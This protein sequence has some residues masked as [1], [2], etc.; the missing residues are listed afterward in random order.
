MRVVMP[1][2]DALSKAPAIAWE[3]TP[4]LLCGGGDHAPIL[5]AADPAG[6]RR[7]FLIVQ[8]SSCGLCFT[9]PRPDSDSMPAFYPAEYRCHQVKERREQRPSWQ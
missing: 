6:A 1:D 2:C 7:R 5:E 4:C 3:E 9:N 8:C